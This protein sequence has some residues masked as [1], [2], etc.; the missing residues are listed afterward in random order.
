M[1]IPWSWTQTANP[2]RFFCQLP[3]TLSEIAFAYSALTRPHGAA[4]ARGG[5]VPSRMAIAFILFDPTTA[6]MPNRCAW[7]VRWLTIEAKRT[8]PSLTGETVG[9]DEQAGAVQG[10]DARFHVLE[11]QPR[12]ENPCAAGYA[13]ERFEQFL[14]A[15]LVA[16]E[17]R[18]KNAAVRTRMA[19]LVDPLLP[20]LTAGQGRRHSGALRAWAAR[21]GGAPSEG[22]RLWKYLTW[23]WCPTQ[24]AEFWRENP[25]PKDLHPGRIPKGEPKGRGGSGVYEGH[26]LAAWHEGV[27]HVTDE[28]PREEF[29]ELEASFSSDRMGTYL[30]AAQ[31]D[32]ERAARLY[33]WNTAVSAAFYGSLQALEVALRNAMHFQLSIPYGEDWYD[34]VGTGLDRRSLGR[35]AD[36]KRELRRRGYGVRPSRMLAELSFGFWVSLLGPGGRLPGSHTRASYE[37]TLWRPALRK[38]FPHRDRLTRPQAHGPLDELRKLRNRIAHHEPIFANDL[39]MDYERILELSGWITPG[40]RAWIERHSRAQDLLETPRD[41][42][43]VR[44]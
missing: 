33:A 31:G 12:R 16:A 2:G 38:A 42:A 30:A 34:N 32:R 8:R 5:R 11:Q 26:I 40:T 37:M 15:R 3:S 19:H 27:K 1:S 25:K 36:A 21:P 41:A 43:T 6:S 20:P 9:E 39:S 22:E 10:V 13:P 28:A 24:T 23:N 7:W 35:I 18:A 29:D 17:V 14:G 44:F 4:S